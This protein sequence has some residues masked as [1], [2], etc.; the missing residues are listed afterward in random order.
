MDLSSRQL[1]ATYLFVTFALGYFGE[2]FLLRTVG[3]TY[4]LPYLLVMFIPGAVGAALAWYSGQ[5]FDN[6]GF[7][8]PADTHWLTAYFVPAAVAI[9]TLGLAVAFGAGHFVYPGGSE[10]TR[11]AVFKSTIGVGVSLVPALGFELG[12]RG[13]MYTHAERAE[14]PLPG[15]LIGLCAA[16]WQWPLVAFGELGNPETPLLSLALFT[17]ANCGASVCLSW[18]RARA[19]SILPLIL[20]H[21]VHAT[22]LHQIVPQFLEG[23]KAKGLFMGE[24][25]LGVA[26][27]YT[28][29]SLVCFKFSAQD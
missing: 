12:W 9:F 1:L 24:A 17:V 3:S 27:G 18:F 5:T 20:A 16:A 26:L 29:L 8:W 7:N 4:S 28:L 2:W 22:W 21:A 14:I 6:F 13:F 10:M 11:L 15:L 23:T 25:G 19:N